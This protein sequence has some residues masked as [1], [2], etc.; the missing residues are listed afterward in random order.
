VATLIKIN[1]KKEHTEQE[2]LQNVHFEEEK[3]TGKNGTESC[4]SRR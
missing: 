4:G 1:N 3:G 2:K